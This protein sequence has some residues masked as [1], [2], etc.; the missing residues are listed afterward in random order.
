MLTL[1]GGPVRLMIA[2]TVAIFIYKTGT[3]SLRG[4]FGDRR[5]RVF[6]RLFLLRGCVAVETNKQ[7]GDGEKESDVSHNCLIV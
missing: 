4:R 2:D 5:L 1:L 3:R 6:S 7:D